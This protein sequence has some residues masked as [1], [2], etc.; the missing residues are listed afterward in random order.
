M[1]QLSLG[2]EKFNCPPLWGTKYSAIKTVRRQRYYR[3]QIE[4]GEIQ[5][6]VIH[7]TNGKVK[8]ELC[9]RDLH[10]YCL[11]RP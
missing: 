1:T 8:F 11:M 7:R 10:V 2:R 5:D 9:K 6:S 3:L 4:E